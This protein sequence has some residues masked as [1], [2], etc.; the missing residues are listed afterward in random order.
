MSHSRFLRTTLRTLHLL[1]FGAFY[2][3]TLFG[4]D[5][6]ALY[7][8]LIA[9]IA[10][11]IIFL[12]FEVSRAP[13]FLIQVRG[14]ATYTKLAL[15]ISTYWFRDYRVSILTAIAII[16]SLVS[17]LPASIRYYVPFK[18]EVIDSEKG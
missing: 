11:G 13:V 4:V 2:G 15:L 6:E 14:L 7:P 17:H 9:V 16:G 10:T 1:A 18:G 12:I 5:N 3:G 8:A